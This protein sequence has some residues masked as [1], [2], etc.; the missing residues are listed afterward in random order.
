MVKECIEVEE[1]ITKIVQEYMVSQEI[2]N[3][4]F[5][6]MLSPFLGVVW[7]LMLGLGGICNS[8][9]LFFRNLEFLFTQWCTPTRCSLAFDDITG[10][11][12]NYTF[13]I[14]RNLE[15]RF[16]QVQLLQSCCY[17]LRFCLPPIL[18]GA[19]PKR[20]GIEKFDPF[21]ILPNTE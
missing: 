14:F 12:W 19:P 13:F 4:R 9:L 3:N 2:W 7:G 17:N 11:I 8:T 21:R 10:W 20:T 6:E 15:F 16:T 18:Q 5:S 1:I